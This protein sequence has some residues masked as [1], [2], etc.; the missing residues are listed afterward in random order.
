MGVYTVIATVTRK[1]S[2]F[3]R[4]HC[5]ASFGLKKLWHILIFKEHGLI[6]KYATENQE[7][8]DFYFIKLHSNH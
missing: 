1:L 3:V 6:N 4:F 2:V 5:A 8:S 7:K